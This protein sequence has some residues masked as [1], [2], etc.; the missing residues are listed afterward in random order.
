MPVELVIVVTV[1][2][3]CLVEGGK[4]LT[5]LLFFCICLVFKAFDRADS[6]RIMA[7]YSEKLL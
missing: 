7:F 2:V 3:M 1:F 6:P 4:K 5:K